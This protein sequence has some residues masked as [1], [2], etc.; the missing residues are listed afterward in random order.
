[1]GGAKA[2]PDNC[3]IWTVSTPA[4]GKR[5]PDVI[6][7]AI[8][9]HGEITNHLIDAVCEQIKSSMIIQAKRVNMGDRN[10]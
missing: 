2:T 5:F 4:K 1:M 10:E 9:V 3:V 6:G 8:I 7:D